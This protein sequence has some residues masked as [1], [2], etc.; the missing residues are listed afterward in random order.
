M[1][2]TCLTFKHNIQCRVD[3]NPYQFLRLNFALYSLYSCS[4]KQ[5]HTA[6]Q[7]QVQPCAQWYALAVLC[8][9][10]MD[11]SETFM[12]KDSVDPCHNTHKHCTVTSRISCKLVCRNPI[13]AVYQ[14]A[15][16]S[17]EA[18]GDTHN[19][20]QFKS[21]LCKIARG[22]LKWGLVQFNGQIWMIWLNT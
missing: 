14:Y 21:A 9:C 22:Q 17:G 18:V 11:V 12:L 4:I 19:V 3:F 7:L 5:N 20:W 8:I 10:R 15:W 16:K 6:P 13:A 2:L 1:Y